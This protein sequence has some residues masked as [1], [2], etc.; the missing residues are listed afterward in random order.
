ML[1]TELLVIGKFYQVSDWAP[2]VSRQLS[3]NFNS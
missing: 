2:F 3:N 1:D